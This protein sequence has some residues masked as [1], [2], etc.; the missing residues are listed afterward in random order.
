MAGWLVSHDM[1]KA[2]FGLGAPLL[3]RILRPVMVYFFLVISLRI[4]GKRELATPSTWWCCFRFPI[5]C[6]TPLS[7]TIIP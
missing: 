2:I 5:R 4:F 6:R 1:W 3:E 7:A